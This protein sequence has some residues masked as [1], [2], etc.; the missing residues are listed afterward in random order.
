[1]YGLVYAI[2]AFAFGVIY[3]QEK[4]DWFKLLFLG[5]TILLALCAT[6]FNYPLCST[7][8]NSVT[9]VTTYSYCSTLEN[10]QG[11]ATYLLSIIAG[12]SLMIFLVRLIKLALQK[13][14]K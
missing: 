5:A 9:G 11:S 4:D 1:M 8:Y 13:W 6:T 2:L 7:T 10:S 3:T 14:G 12:V